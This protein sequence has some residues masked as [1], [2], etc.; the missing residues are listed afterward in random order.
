MRY[1]NGDKIIVY[2]KLR[3]WHLGDFADKDV[4]MRDRLIMTVRGPCIYYDEATHRCWTT[5][6]EKHFN[7][8]DLSYW[9]DCIKPSKETI[10]IISKR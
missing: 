10:M 1:K 9:E 5:R 6:H 8:S 3:D 2:Q 4:P 7:G